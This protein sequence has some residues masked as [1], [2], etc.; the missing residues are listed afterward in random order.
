[1]E[2]FIRQHLPKG[3]A[4]AFTDGELVAINAKRPAAAA[5]RPYG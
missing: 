3:S 1:V 2:S 4:D 5:F